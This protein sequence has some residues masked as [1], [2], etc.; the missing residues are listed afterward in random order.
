[1]ERWKTILDEVLHVNK[2]WRYCHAIYEWKDGRRGDYYYVEMLGFSVVVPVLDDGRIVITV[3]YR[4]LM[5]KQSIEFP[6]GKIELGDDPLETA[7][8]ELEEETGWEAD[9]YIRVGIIE[10]SPAEIKNPGH[11][12]LAQAYGQKEAHPNDTEQ[13]EVL[14]RRPDEIDEMIKRND[15]WDG[16]TIATWAMVRHHF[17]DK[18]YAEISA[19]KVILPDIS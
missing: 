1:M 11:I 3:K 9:Q 5:D 17:L 2:W 7:K 4:Y 18:D 19:P 16:P 15:I 12:F 10:P 8:R 14:Y 6:A 13:I